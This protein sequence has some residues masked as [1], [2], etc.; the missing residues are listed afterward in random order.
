[1]IMMALLLL[2]LIAQAL[3]TL[4]S[5]DQVADQSATI[6]DHSVP[7]TLLLLN[8]DR[9]AYQAQLALERAGAL[10]NSE[11]RDEYLTSFE[12]NAGQTGD[13]FAQ[14]QEIAYRLEGEDELAAEFISLR[15][16]WLGASSN[17]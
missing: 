7:A 1:M 2:P 13:R 5:A 4:R 15:E 10:T 8:V 3:I 17:V 11:T 6:A 14:F 9:D 12:E 16:V